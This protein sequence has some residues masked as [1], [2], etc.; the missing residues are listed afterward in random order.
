MRI[1]LIG[2]GIEGR[3]AYS[4]FKR[5]YTDAQFIIYDKATT[6]AP[7]VP[8]DV[9]YV[10]GST[11]IYNIDA[12]LVIRT[13]SIAP[14]RIKT[15]GKVSSVTQEFFERCPVPIIAVTGTKGKGTTASLIA[16][17]LEEAGKNVYLLGNIGLSALD[18]LDAVTQSVTNYGPESTVVVYELSSYQAWNLTKSPHVAVVLGIESE[19]LD[20]H[21]DLDDYIN[22]KANITK[23][24]HSDDTVIY[25]Q[26]N[27]LSQRVATFSPG[28]VVAY[29][30]PENEAFVIDGTLI[31]KRSD[32]PL[33]GAHNTGNIMAACLAAWQFTHDTAALSRAIMR[34]TG[35]EHRLEIVRELHDVVYVNDS[36]STAPTATIA[37]LASFDR[38]IILILGGHDKG[39]N[40]DEAIR[41]IIHQRNVKYYFLIGETASKLASLCQHEQIKNYKIGGNDF[42][43]IIKNVQQKTKPGDAVLFSPGAASFGMFTNY[44]QRGSEFKRIVAELV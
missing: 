19:H 43:Q 11:D 33:L 27:I 35:L 7:D 24:Q 4:W 21:A 31:A 28:R 38:P 9:K 26:P 13:P 16:A 12:D 8:S 6:A 3:S 30:V 34:F 40:Q 23:H 14:N 25:Y 15:N 41:M 36:F 42:T 39:A 5:H 10:G 20:V 29:R 32:S 22:A 37:A 18:K 1:A 2:Y 17:M 44:S